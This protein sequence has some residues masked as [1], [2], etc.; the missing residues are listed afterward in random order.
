M[1]SFSVVLFSFLI[2]A[3]TGFGACLYM[4]PHRRALRWRKQLLKMMMKQLA[5]GNPIAA[6]LDYA[7]K[8]KGTLSEDYRL[9]DDYDSKH[10]AA[11]S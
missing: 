1:S 6:P 2:G 10:K 3:A 7:P 4:A 11:R 5:T 9:H 8:A